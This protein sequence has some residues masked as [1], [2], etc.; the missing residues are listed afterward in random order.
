M[1][2]AP[3]LFVEARRRI[4]N[5]PSNSYCFEFCFLA[6]S[7]NQP[8]KTAISACDPQRNWGNS[9]SVKLPSPYL[10]QNTY[11]CVTIGA[12]IG[13]RGFTKLRL[14]QVWFVEKALDEPRLLKKE[15][16]P[17]F[18]SILCQS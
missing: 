3:R 14:S 5:R 7:S 11:F 9:Q 2:F 12:I 8:E 17:V 4:P 6:H 18:V 13:D 15:L 16:L 10:T 1:K